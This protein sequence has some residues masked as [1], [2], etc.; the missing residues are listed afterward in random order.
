MS[1]FLKKD[2]LLPIFISI[3]ILIIYSI[4]YVPLLHKGNIQQWDE[5]YTLERSSGFMQHQDW[6]TVY[7]NNVP[8][9]NKPPLQYWLT[10]LFLKKGSNLEFSLR[11]WSF[12]FGISLLGA[13]GLLAHAILPARPYAMPAAMLVLSGSSLFWSCSIS[14]MLD[15]GAALFS[16]VAIASFLLALRNPKWWYVAA[17]S[18]GLGALQKAPIALLAIV[19][20]GLVAYSARN[21]FNV[22]LREIFRNIHF[23][24]STVMAGLMVCFWPLLQTFMYGKK[25][26][27]TAFVQQM[28]DRFI[29][30][31][32]FS[33]SQTKWWTWLFEGDVLLWL[34]AVLAMTALV[35]FRRRLETIIPAVLVAV[36]CVTMTLATGRIYERYILHA[37]PLLAAALG[38]A[39]ALA[40]PFRTMVLGAAL[41]LAVLCGQPFQTEDTLNLKSDDKSAFIPFLQDF[42]RALQDNDTPVRCVW[43]DKWGQVYPGAIHYFA[44]NGRQF[45]VIM[46]PEKL[47]QVGRPPYRGL[48]PIAQF[49]ELEALWGNLRVVAEFQGW[50]HWVS[51]SPLVEAREMAKNAAAISPE[52]EKSTSPAPLLFGD[53]ARHGRDS[54]QRDNSFLVAG[55]LIPDG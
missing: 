21:V 1:R 46:G 50:V 27:R 6:F 14:A 48:C 39:L 34:P 32:N 45:R 53:W 19:I 49:G 9:F 2:I 25:Y 51:G 13:T 5:Y 37:L 31:L 23:K 3:V 28:Y 43:G 35:F 24:R 22:S 40:F 18:V 12:V 29:P 20:S 11:I 38:A 8:D 47:G 30:T 41:F 36:F 10:A 16:T 52:G 54:R 55:V 26:Y 4:Y 7:T 42:A 44:G 15:A 17:V 33:D